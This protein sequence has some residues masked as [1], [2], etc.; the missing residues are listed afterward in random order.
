MDFHIVILTDPIQVEDCQSLP[1]QRV[2]IGEREFRKTFDN[3]DDVFYDFVVGP[4]MEIRALQLQVGPDHPLCEVLQLHRRGVLHSY[5]EFT[6]CLR[7]WL[8]S[9]HDG[10]EVGAEAFG[11]LMIFEADDDTMAIGFSSNWLR[12]T[13][14][15]C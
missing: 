2:K 11:D 14:S 1:L 10:K 12:N 7:I 4:E 3:Y 15:G 5:V 6:P 8:T 9:I 13:K